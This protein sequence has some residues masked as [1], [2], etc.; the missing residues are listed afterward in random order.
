MRHTPVVTPNYL[1]TLAVDSLITTLASNREFLKLTW[2]GRK[3]VGRYRY[4]GYLALGLFSGC[5]SQTNSEEKTDGN[6]KWPDFSPETRGLTCMR[7]A[8]LMDRGPGRRVLKKSA[9]CMPCGCAAWD[10]ALCHPGP[11]VANHC[12]QTRLG[13]HCCGGLQLA[14]SA[15]HDA[16]QTGVDEMNRVS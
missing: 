14:V 4:I 10:D 1:W 5:L 16:S 2:G 3:T 12:Q 9:A 15:A 13:V 11:F 6:L 8:A 7:P